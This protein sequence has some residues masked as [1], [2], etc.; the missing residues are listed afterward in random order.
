MCAAARSKRLRTPTKTLPTRSAT[1]PGKPPR[2]PTAAKPP[3]ANASVAKA[4]QT[5]RSLRSHKQQQQQQS[6]ASE[7]SEEQ[8]QALTA[9]KM[10]I[11]TTAA[12]FWAEVA[13]FVDGK[14]ADECRT[15]SFEE[16]ASPT[17]RAT[18]RKKAA[19]APASAS[20]IPTKI[21]RAG[22]NL[23]KKQVRTFVQDY[24]K[25]H[26]D[27]VFADTTPTKTEIHG[28][29]GLD[30]LQSPSAPLDTSVNLDDDDADDFVGGREVLQEITSSKRDEVDSYVLSLKRNR[31]IGEPAKSS[32]STPSTL[33]KKTKTMV[34]CE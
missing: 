18:T 12:N 34:R 22:S 33:K 2:T 30:D 20:K 1:T 15:K 32:F 27:D 25:K 8:L 9:A 11:P 26:I 13:T 5:I 16:F 31:L 21:H 6:D 24:E 14:S 4:K 7:W 17:S 28:A 10:Q 23:F 19:A 29:L 3:R